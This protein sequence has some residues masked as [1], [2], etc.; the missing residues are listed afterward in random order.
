VFLYPTNI[1]HSEKY[2]SLSKHQHPRLRR[3]FGLCQHAVQERCSQ[4]VHSNIGKLLGAKF[5]RCRLDTS[6]RTKHV[7]EFTNSRSRHTH[8]HDYSRRPAVNSNLYS[9]RKLNSNKK[10]IYE[11][12]T[13]SRRIHTTIDENPTAS[14]AFYSTRARY[15]RP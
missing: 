12:G 10:Y 7:S 6:C 1:L 14:S 8:S 5:G 4:G 2:S 9:I 15:A 13:A 11:N 3:C